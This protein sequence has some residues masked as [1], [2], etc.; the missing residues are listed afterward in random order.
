MC[1]IVGFIGKNNSVDFLLEGLKRLE[2]RGYDSAGLATLDNSK[3]IQ[4]RKSVGKIKNLEELL[5]SSP[6]D[7]NIGI[8]H[9]RWATHG[10]PNI[11]NAHPHITE[12]LSVVHNGIIENYK[13]LKEKLIR[14][15]H[16]FISET[17]TE[18]IA[19]LVTDY[20]E[21]NNEL[22]ACKKAI[23]ELDG[24][25]AIAVLF[26]GNDKFLV[27]S[28]KGSPLALGYG[29]GEMY[30][31]SDAIALAPITSKISYLEEGD[32]AKISREKAII[33]DSGD[34]EVQREISY[35]SASSAM[36]GKGEYN[37]FMQKEIFE[38]PQVISYTLNS[39]I[40]NETQEIEIEGFDMDV[41]NISSINIIACGTSYH[42]S[43]TAKYWIEKLAKINVNVDVASE[44]RYRNPVL[45]KNGLA[46]F[47][48]Q[49]GETADTLAALRLCK[50]HGQKILSVVNV[51][52]STISRESDIVL[53]TLA[54]PEIGVASTKAFTTQLSVFACL[55]LK[56]A[57]DKQTISNSDYKKYIKELSE[58]SSKTI[59]VLKLDSKIKNIAKSI[60]N[61]TSA[62]YLGRGVGFPLALEGALKLKEISY[63][64]AEGYASGEMK[65]GPIALI[66]EGVPVVVMG[67]NDE[68]FEKNISNMQEIIARNGDVI[69]ISD[70]NGCAIVDGEIK[71]KIC[72]PPVSNFIAP[73]IFALPIQILAYHT[74]V[75]KGTDVDQPRNLAKSVTVE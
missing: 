73:I 23:K 17:D 30:I 75:L 16:K 55:A 3:Q 9:T 13:E 52:E 37:H 54:G 22:E 71:H 38:Q 4:T 47:V 57:K 39:L 1:G 63:I 12:K 45:P 10:V 41:D 60:T 11:V 69:F 20:L 15:G 7:S 33:F 29:E 32:I 24:A 21:H 6:I 44:F 28:R 58:I 50:E 68:L 26:N 59:E 67:I 53:Q 48:S 5:A 40:N 65:H 36:I 66:E 64:H 61:A 70:D 31:G 2:Y 8:G 34:K 72:I 49:S 46:I 19:H 25:F 43:M 27:A 56:F 62:L 42:A 18:V 35:S 74:S 14:K 51:K